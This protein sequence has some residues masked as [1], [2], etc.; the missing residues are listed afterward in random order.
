MTNRRL[1]FVVLAVGLAL[2]ALLLLRT[3]RDLFLRLVPVVVISLGILRPSLLE[4]TPARSSEPIR[5]IRS[6]VAPATERDR[7]S[8]AWRDLENNNIDYNIRARL[9]PASVLA[10]LIPLS[11][12]SR[13]SMRPA[14]PTGAISP[15]TPF[16]GSG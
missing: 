6:I 10:A 14:L 15:I 1:G 7:S 3:R 4:W 11:W 2:V 5:A 13:R 16:T 9:S 8:N 12:R